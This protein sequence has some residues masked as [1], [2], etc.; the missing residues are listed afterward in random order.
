MSEIL[1]KIRERQM[2]VSCDTKIFIVISKIGHIF[3][4]YIQ[5]L[6]TTTG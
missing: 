3:I 6:H 2:T 5:D 4:A 1:I